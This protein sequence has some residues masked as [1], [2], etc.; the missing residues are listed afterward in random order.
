MLLLQSVLLLLLLLFAYSSGSAGNENEEDEGEGEDVKKQ[1]KEVE[2]R[3]S[4]RLA[5]LAARAEAHTASSPLSSV[6]DNRSGSWPVKFPE[7]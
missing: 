7:L 5:N 6:A 4:A 2:E 3:E 1:T